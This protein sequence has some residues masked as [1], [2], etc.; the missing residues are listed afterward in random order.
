M[1]V[2]HLLCNGLRLLQQPDM[3]KKYLLSY[4]EEGKE[5]EKN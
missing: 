3:K 4:L 2:Y 1:Q 5:P